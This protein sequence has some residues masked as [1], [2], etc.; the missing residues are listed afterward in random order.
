VL[1]PAETDPPPPFWGLVPVFCRSP[2]FS[3]VSVLLHSFVFFRCDGFFFFLGF[4]QLFFFFL[5]SPPFFRFKVIGVRQS[6]YCLI[7]ALSPFLRPFPSLPSCTLPAPWRR[8]REPFL[9]LPGQGGF[10]SCGPCFFS[11]FCGWYMF[12]TADSPSLQCFFFS[13]L[14]YFFSPL[15]SWGVLFFLRALRPFW[16]G[17]LSPS[18]LSSPRR[19]RNSCFSSEGRR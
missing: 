6:G 1:F 4:G 5:C 12:H 10:L 19:D 13:F 8:R 14:V 16:P 15:L 18:S 17:V 7:R 2:L 9:A 3:L 11:P